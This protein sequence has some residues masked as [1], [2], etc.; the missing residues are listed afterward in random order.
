MEELSKQNEIHPGGP[1][2]C[3]CI[4]LGTSSLFHISP[5]P[6]FSVGLQE[7]PAG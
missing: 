7:L 2:D 4:V 5:D 1:Q 6:A 3:L